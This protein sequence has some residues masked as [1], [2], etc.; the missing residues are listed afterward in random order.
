[1]ENLAQRMIQYRAKHGGISQDELAKLCHVSRQVIRYI[2]AG[3]GCSA[4]TQAKISM[5]INKEDND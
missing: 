5:I 4:L 1:M 3:K 2:E